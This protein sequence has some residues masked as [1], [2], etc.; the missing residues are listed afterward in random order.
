MRNQRSLAMLLSTLLLASPLAMA[1]QNGHSQGQHQTQGGQ[2]QSKNGGHGQ[3]GARQ[4]GQGGQNQA[5]RQGPSPHQ[6]WQRGQAVPQQYRGGN[7]VV[8]DWRSRNLAPPP[9]GQHWLQVNGDFVLAAIATG[10]IYSII[11]R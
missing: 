6:D 11:S 9:S 4:S 8:N 10:V 3:G 5:K 2:G 7:Y 1:Q